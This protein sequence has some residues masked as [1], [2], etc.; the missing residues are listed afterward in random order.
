VYEKSLTPC[1]LVNES[2]VRQHAKQTRAVRGSI[3]L[4]HVR[5]ESTI[6]KLLK[7]Q[8]LQ[9][10]IKEHKQNWTNNLDG[11][12]DENANRNYIAKK[13]M[14]YQGEEDRTKD[15]LKGKDIFDHLP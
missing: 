6:R 2:G 14:D 3:E 10:K 8:S 12:T 5:N 13:R 9:N 15:E 4:D 1:S 11:V 7:I